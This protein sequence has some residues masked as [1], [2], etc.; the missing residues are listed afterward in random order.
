MVKI[1][2]I[3]DEVLIDDI[4]NLRKDFM[5]ECGKNDKDYE[6]STYN[7]ASKQYFSK[8]IKDNSSCIFAAAKDDK[9]IGYAAMSFYSI[10]PT[11]RNLSGKAG[12]LTDMYV[13]PSNRRKGISFKMLKEI[14][15]YAESINVKKVTLN[16]TELGRY[17]YEKYGFT[18]ISGEMC[19][20]LK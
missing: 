12:I 11:M 8:G 6:W 1:Y 16:A 3:N 7:K 5:I 15:N 9:I 2:K 10:C 17:V 14:M 4:I 18:D 19:R 13:V 20:K